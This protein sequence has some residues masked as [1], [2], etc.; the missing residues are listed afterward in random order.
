MNKTEN[1]AKIRMGQNARNFRLLNRMDTFQQKRK[2]FD[3]L[4]YLNYYSPEHRHI[5]L[6]SMQA[7]IPS[8]LPQL[9]P[10][11]ISFYRRNSIPIFCTKSNES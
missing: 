3:Q 2:T 9:S 8:P 5:I 1:I 7:P 4:D 10:S 6:N 11:T